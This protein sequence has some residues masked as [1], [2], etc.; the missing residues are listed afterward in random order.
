MPF[1]HPLPFGDGRTYAGGA[2]TL[3]CRERGSPA[4]F[5]VVEADEAMIRITAFGWTGS[6]FE[7]QR[8]WG[9]DRRKAAA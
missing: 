1:A 4:G 5:N 8:S 6:H 7:P 3:S 9:F 2:G